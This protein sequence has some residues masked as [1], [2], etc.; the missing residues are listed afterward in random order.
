[1]KWLLNTLRTVSPHAYWAIILFLF[2][3]W[4]VF[5][6]VTSQPTYGRPLVT[7]EYFWLIGGILLFFLLIFFGWDRDT[8]R[9]V[10]AKLAKGILTGILITVTTIVVLVSL[11]EWYLR[12]FY[13][14]TDGYGFTSMN[15]WW[16]QN[17]GLA[18]DNSLG[19]RDAEPIADSPTLVRVAVLGDSFAMGHGINNR[20][21]VF[22][23]RLEES[24]GES[25][26]VNLI[27]DSGRDTDLHLPFLEQYPY[28]PDILIYSYYLN[29]ID[30]LLSEER[31]P[32]ANFTFIQDE[33]TENFVRTFFLPNYIYYNL[34]Q[35]TSSQRAGGFV[36]TLFSA[37]ED[38]TLW[39]EHQ[40]RLNQMI[41]YAEA[42]NIPMI[43]LLW[44]HLT[45]IE[46]S[47]A[48]LQ[49]VRDVYAARGIP[50]VDMTPILRDYDPAQLIVNR[51]DA[52]PSILAHQLAAQA[53]EPAVRDALLLLSPAS[54]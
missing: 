4:Q 19:Y 18:Q 45:A 22:A 7:W 14:T 10:G 53:L 21:D 20:E 46:Q 48:A 34:L 1:M 25:Y 5:W 38:D 13:I 29:D 30:Y 28:P 52:H 42:N 15:Y 11:G 54:D 2:L 17:F 27:A 9:E 16:Y 6:I 12:L 41:D 35:F 8:A 24:L 49:R 43:V 33:R 37:Y 51:F 3:A 47:Q 32:D 23:Q 50:L 26:D 36:N 31:N 39:Q 44:P 40:F